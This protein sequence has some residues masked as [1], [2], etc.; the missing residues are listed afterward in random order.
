MKGGN[1]EGQAFT[2]LLKNFETSD[3][4]PLARKKAVQFLEAKLTVRRWGEG[5]GAA[6]KG[7]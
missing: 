1:F 3:C 7:P 5:N 4:K 2:F 6:V